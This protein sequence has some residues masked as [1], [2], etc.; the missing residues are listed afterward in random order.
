MSTIKVLNKNEVE[1][2]MTVEEYDAFLEAYKAKNPVKY[3][4]KEARGEFEKFRQTLPGYV[5]P[6][7]SAPSKLEELSKAELKK[8]AEEKEVELKGTESKAELLEMLKDLN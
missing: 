4:Q 6:Q 7:S 8:L 1:P 2:M 3:A 5:P